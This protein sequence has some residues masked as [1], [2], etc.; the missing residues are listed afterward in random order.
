MVLFSFLILLT[1]WPALFCFWAYLCLVKLDLRGQK[2]LVDAFNNLPGNNLSVFF[3]F[4]LTVGK[5]GFY[6]PSL[7]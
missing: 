5:T 4:F 7:Q 6:F 3:F 1:N 2:K